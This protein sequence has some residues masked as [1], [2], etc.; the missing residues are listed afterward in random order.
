MANTKSA[1]KRIRIIKKRTLRNK[2]IRSNVKTM[3]KKFER[4]LEAGDIEGAK[5]LFPQVVKRIDMAA[6][7]GVIHRNT[8]NR[9][10]SR[11]AIR[12]NR[13]LAQQQAAQ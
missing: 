7:K 10:K 12:L 2:M 9:K 3:I 13:A 11:L 6:S 1:L 4:A 5:A 8:A